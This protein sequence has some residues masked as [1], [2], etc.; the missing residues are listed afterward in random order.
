M[1][2]DDGAAKVGCLALTVIQISPI[3]SGRD[4]NTVRPRSAIGN[5]SSVSRLNCSKG[6]IA[7]RAITP[8]NTPAGW[9]KQGA[10]QITAISL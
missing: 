10:R 8:E 3:G 9:S 6:A 7:P 2:L 4:Y 1:N 5:K